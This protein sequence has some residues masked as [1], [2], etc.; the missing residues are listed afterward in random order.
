MYVCKNRGKMVWYHSKLRRNWKVAYSSKKTLIK[1]HAY[2][3]DH[4]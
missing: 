4:I 3:C 2:F 1:S